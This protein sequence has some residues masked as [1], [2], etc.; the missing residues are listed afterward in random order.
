MW[1]VASGPG[2]MSPPYLKD[3]AN[4]YNS[5]L[6]WAALKHDIISENLRPKIP[7]NTP[8]GFAELMQECWRGNPKERPSFE[9]VA[10]R[11]ASLAGTRY[12]PA[13]A[14]YTQL[15]STN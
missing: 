4:V 7:E 13:I 5:S 14:N 3:Y 6:N 9:V 2:P 8:P 10:Q 12:T 1:E 11:L 15:R